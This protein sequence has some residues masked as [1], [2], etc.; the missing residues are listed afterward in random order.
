MK[1]VRSLSVVLLVLVLLAGCASNTPWRKATVVTFELVGVGIGATK[2]TTELLKAQGVISDAQLANIKEIYNKAV[3]TYAKAGA[4][5]KL[6]GQVASAS[7]R[8]FNLAEY[9]KFIGEFA[10]LSQQLYD[11]IKGFK[12]VSLNDTLELIVTEI[13][14]SI[15]IYKGGAL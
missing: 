6:A 3:A 8:D 9:T 13:P 15:L 4:A 1:K 12:K 14:G 10:S 5:L 7:E 2:D 11:L